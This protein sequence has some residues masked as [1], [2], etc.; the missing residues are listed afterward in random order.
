MHYLRLAASFAAALLTGFL[1]RWHF[2]HVPKADGACFVVKTFLFL[3]EVPP[4]KHQD[5]V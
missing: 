1:L 5:R 4:L 3:S 2:L